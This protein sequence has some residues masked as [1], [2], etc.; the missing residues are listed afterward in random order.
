MRLFN[1]VTSLMSGVSLYD[2][3]CG[4]KIYRRQV[5]DDAPI[6][7]E[8]YCCIPVGP[9]DGALVYGRPS[10]WQS[11]LAGTWSASGARAELHPAITF[12]L[13][14]VPKLPYQDQVFD[15]VICNG[16]L[17]HLSHSEMGASL[18]L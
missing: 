13:G 7:G 4:F 14:D 16:V 3:S 18:E 8:L 15:L 17:E 9:P 6:Y 1:L 10:H 12:E 11:S 5:V 2:F